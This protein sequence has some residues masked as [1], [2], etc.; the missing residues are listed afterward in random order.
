MLVRLLQFL[1]LFLLIRF[2]WRAVATWLEGSEPKRVENRTGQQSSGPIYRGQMVRDPVCGIFVP[3]DRSL[4]ER[5]GT[6]I[7]HF[8][9]E[10][11][12]E[13]YRKGE[14]RTEANA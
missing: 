10:D 1:A 14:I 2:V 7:V 12:R 13:R 8:C 6:S 9:S 11:C 5:I 3:K 4:K